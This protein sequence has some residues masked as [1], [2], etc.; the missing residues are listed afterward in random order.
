VVVLVVVVLGQQRSHAAPSCVHVLRLL[1]LQHSARLLLDVGLVH[2]APRL[3][4]QHLLHCHLVAVRRHQQLRRRWLEV[5]L[6]LLLLLWPAPC[7][8]G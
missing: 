5:R 3:L 4:N 6:V 8:A 1:R 7:V 2:R